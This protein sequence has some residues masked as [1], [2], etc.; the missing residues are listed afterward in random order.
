MEGS[1]VV[2]SKVVVGAPS[3]A[4]AQAAE[5]PGGGAV[6]PPGPGVIGPPP[7]G[8]LGPVG[9]AGGGVVGPP[10]PQLALQVA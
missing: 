2:G 9:P 8:K 10:S 6:G 7:P 1:E 4:Q 3:R 5:P